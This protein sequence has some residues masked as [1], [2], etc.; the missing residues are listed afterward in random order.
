MD[1]DGFAAAM[2]EQKDKARKARKTTNYMGADVTVYQSIDAAITT[3]FIGYDRLSAESKISVLTTEDELVEALT[4]GQRGTI[5]VDA[6]PF[7]GT[8]G[9]QQGDIGYIRSSQ[10]E[11]KVEDTIHLQGGKVGHV[12]VMTSGMFKVGDT[13]TLSVDPVNRALTCKNHSATHLLQKALRTVLGDHGEQAGSYVTRK[14][15]L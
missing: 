10:G 6:T 1:E 4:D 14:A 13:V 12:G 8:M 15:A 5:L 7:Y 2:K 3:E 9:G 11:F